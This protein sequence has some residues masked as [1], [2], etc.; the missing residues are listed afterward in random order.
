LAK[1]LGL[2]ETTFDHALTPRVLYAFTA[3]D[4]GRLICEELEC[5]KAQYRAR[6]E[7]RSKA[8]KRG[9]KALHNKGKKMPGS[10]MAQPPRV[11]MASPE[12]RRVEQ[13]RDEVSRVNNLNTS[14]A[15]E[16]KEYEKAWETSGQVSGF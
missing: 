15:E 14:M 5:L 10:A 4:D 8:G 6:H 16:I 2:D 7:E 12:K 3:R 13:R 9:A 1:L 11:A